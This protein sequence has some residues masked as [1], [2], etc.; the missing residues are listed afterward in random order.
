MPSPCN[1]TDNDESF[2]SFA[3]SNGLTIFG[4][5]LEMKNCTINTLITYPFFLRNRG[6]FNVVCLS[7]VKDDLTCTAIEDRI[8]LAASHRTGSL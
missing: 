4:L 5:Q 3:V 1:P 6:S 8:T 2:T 7:I